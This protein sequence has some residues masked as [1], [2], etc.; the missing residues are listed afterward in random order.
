MLGA[1]LGA[2]LG[3]VAVPEAEI[4]L[5]HILAIQNIQG[6]HVQLGGAHQEPRAGEGLL[7]LLVVADHVADVLAQEAFDALAELLGALHIL[8]GHPVLAGLQIL[9]RGEGRN[10]ARLLVIE[11]HVGD[12]IPDHR[13]RPQRG[14]RDGFGLVEGR[15]PGHAHQPWPAIDL[16]RTRSALAGLAVPPH[17]EVGCLLGLQTV[18]DVQDDL[19]VVDVDGE[20]AQIAAVVVAAPH[21][22][23]CLV[24]HDC[25]SVRPGCAASSSSV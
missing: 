4:F 1:D 3:D 17:R 24:G 6:V 2:A 5:R 7:V 11:R 9:G 15:H 21:P 18:D 20:V 10:L 25:S 23:L 19:T 13:E 12:Q 14:D 22:E 8:L 16:G